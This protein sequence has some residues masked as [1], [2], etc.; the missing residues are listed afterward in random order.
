MS[1]PRYGY[2]NIPQRWAVRISNN[3]E[4]IHANPDS[5]DAQGNT[6]VTHGCVNLSSP[7]PRPTTTRRSG[8]TRSRSPAP[9][10]NLARR[11]ATSTSGACPGTSGRPVHHAVNRSRT[12]DA[13]TERRVRIVGADCGGRSPG[14]GAR[15]TRR[16]RSS[17]STGLIS[18]LGRSAGPL[19]AGDIDGT[20]RVAAP[21]LINGHT[22]AGISLLRGHSD[23]EP[24]QQWLDPHPGL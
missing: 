10:C 17:P 18:Y 7:T 22:H 11:T 3:G 12:G 4:F 23:D 2:T 8:A 15:G 6:N 16:S 1:N 9:T 21:G 5:A 13:V 19:G 14:A 24:L 20:G